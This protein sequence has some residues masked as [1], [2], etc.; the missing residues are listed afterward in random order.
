MLAALFAGAM[1]ARRLVY[2]QTPSTQSIIQMED[3]LKQMIQLQTAEHWYR[4]II[5]IGEQ[6][7]ILGIPTRDRHLLFGIRMKVIA[8]I[9]LKDSGFRLY[10]RGGA[11]YAALPEARVLA[12][13]A[14]DSSIEEYV[15]AGRGKPVSMLTYFDE[16]SGAKAVAQADAVN[17]G[18]LEQAENNAK[19]I[20]RN[21]LAMA[22]A[23]DVRF[24]T[25]KPSSTG[26]ANDD[27][28]EAQQ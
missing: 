19:S 27:P 2:A 18:I 15:S 20:I 9:D 22:G 11:V 23:G 7:K 1:L 13:D 14:D 6:S 28:R 16:I 25:A 21:L 8:G 4:D 17:R 3:Q 10:R 26:E 5:Y 12:V 24:V